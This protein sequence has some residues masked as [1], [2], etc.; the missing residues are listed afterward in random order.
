M[1]SAGRSGRM[2]KTSFF[3]SS[4]VVV[5]F[6]VG[7]PYDPIGV[8]IAYAACN[9]MLFVP[10]LWYSTRRMPVDMFNILNV[11]KHPI[12]ASLGVGISFIAFKL[13]LPTL[14]TGINGLA[15]GFF[16]TVRVYLVICC[17]LAG[18]LIPIAELI[19]LVSHMFRRDYEQ[20][21][22]QPQC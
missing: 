8:A 11:I 9:L 20:A 4:C 15:N 13:C 6:F 19:V 14:S 5:A 1:I 17:I 3:F 22:L 7:L 12:L 18:G 21:S 2:S 16:G 10:V